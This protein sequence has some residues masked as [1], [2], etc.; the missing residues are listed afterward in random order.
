M[1]VLGPL[2]SEML[3][4]HQSINVQQK[5]GYIIW[6]KGDTIINIQT[7]LEAIGLGVIFRDMLMK[8]ERVGIGKTP[9]FKGWSEGRA[10]SQGIWLKNIRQRNKKATSFS[11]C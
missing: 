7:K 10:G 8:L 4:R 3:L 1:L 2:L 11:E 5:V 9:T 6:G